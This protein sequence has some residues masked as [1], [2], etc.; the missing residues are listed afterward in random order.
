LGGIYKQTSAPQGKAGS[1]TDVMSPNK[2]RLHAYDLHRMIVR[3]GIP[4]RFN[5]HH[6]NKTMTA[7]R[8]LAGLKDN[9]DVEKA[10]NALFEG[11]FMRFF[12]FFD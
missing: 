6:P 3:N 12:G 5:S 2:R 11:I 7:Q 10:S 8:L 9:S 4:F 1:A